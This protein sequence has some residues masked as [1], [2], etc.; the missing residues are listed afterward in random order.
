[1]TDCEET[2]GVDLSPDRPSTDPAEDRLGYAPFAKRLAESIVGLTGTEGHVIA[3]YGP[4]GFGK[5]T[6]LNYVRHFVSERSPEQQPII[7]TF[8]PW[9]FA[10]SEDLI[11]AFFKQL[12]A[13]LEGH[14]ELSEIRKRLADFAEALGEVPLPHA[15]LIKIGAKLLR[16]KPKGIAKLKNDVSDA[17][18]RQT[19]RILV[20]VDDV[21]RLTSEEIRQMFR[22]IKAVADF[23]RLTYLMAFDKQVVARSLGELQGGSGEDYLEKIVQVPFD[24]P[25]V[26]RL[27]MRS[28]FFEKLNP[29]LSQIDPR[30]FDEVYWGNLFFDG[31]DKFLETPRDIVRLTNTMAV[32]FPAVLGEVNAVD[33]IAIECLRMFCPEAYDCIRQNREMFA[34]HTARDLERPT[35]E[36]L[37]KFHS[38]WLD[39]LGRSN[40]AHSKAARNMA[41]R[42]FPKLKSVW[43]NTHYGFEWESRWRRD[44]RICSEDVFPVYFSFGIPSGEISNS[45]M[46]AILA[47]AGDAKSFGTHL[48]TLSQQMRPGGK[49]KASA[50]LDRIQ[51]YT[52]NEISQDQ[53]GPIVSA[54]FDIGDQLIKPQDEGHGLIGYGNDVQ[55]G[56]VSWQLLQRLD[57]DRRFSVLRDA[58]ETG[59]ALYLMQRSYIVMAQ[60]QGMYGES[61]RPEQEWLVTREQLVELEC[62]LIAKIR[63]AGTDGSL[64]RI[65]KLLPVLG[66]WREKRGPEEV[67]AWVAETVKDD[68][69]LVEFLERCLHSSSS[70]GAGDSVSR[71]VDRL[72]PEWIRPYLDPDQIVDRVRRLSS[73]SSFTPLQKRALDEFLKEYDLRK[74]GGN[75]DSPLFRAGR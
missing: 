41:E 11:C 31:I 36:E 40:P 46:Q 1:M 21:D 47:E 29:I 32:T 58:F 5:T 65:P 68:E 22:T 56:R 37:S 53:I 3:L 15:E 17:L 52:Q 70:F 2:D 50:L 54:L 66:L 18:Q 57:P 10:G 34:G 16:S 38:E 60:Q 20:V 39:R 51:D 7:L 63:A 49:T 19:R 61:A 64:L 28:F 44:L 71:R 26:D 74:K 9:W 62:V 55:A 14:K 24:L 73:D 67:Q 75:P 30:H 8:N 23:P 27:S 13:L 72:D 45:E 42:L 43:G 35:S 59:H 25:L 4:W 48:L 6:M 69:N 12:L 33:F